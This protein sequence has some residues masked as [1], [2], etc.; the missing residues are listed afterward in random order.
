MSEGPP[1]FKCEVVACHVMLRDPDAIIYTARVHAPSGRAR[2]VHA[3]VKHMEIVVGKALSAIREE[4]FT[5][6]EDIDL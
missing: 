1:R 5:Y 2:T 3:C 4:P 6:M